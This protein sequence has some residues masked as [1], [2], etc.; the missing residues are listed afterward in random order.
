MLV[1]EI[2]LLA[3]VCRSLLANTL[4]DHTKSDQKLGRNHPLHATLA[5]FVNIVAILA[6]FLVLAAPIL[7]LIQLTVMALL[8]AGTVQLIRGVG[9]EQFATRKRLSFAQ[10]LG[11]ILSLLLGALVLLYITSLAESFP[12][13]AASVP[14]QLSWQDKEISLL[15]L[16]S[17]VMVSALMALRFLRSNRRTLS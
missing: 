2:T 9:P 1:L 13:P 11:L 16:G 6:L 7:A 14:F 10:L 12:P 5:A 3:Y 17:L 4:N 15:A 8:L